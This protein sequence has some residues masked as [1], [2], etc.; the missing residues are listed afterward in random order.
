MFSFNRH[1]TCTN[2]KENSQNNFFPTVANLSIF[3]CGQL[4]CHNRHSDDI[5]HMSPC[6]EVSSVLPQ[7]R[8]PLR[9]PS[10]VIVFVCDFVDEI[11]HVTP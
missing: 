6:F 4:C 2:K 1:P 9:G 5:R 8:H 10:A 3:Y 11:P 7:P